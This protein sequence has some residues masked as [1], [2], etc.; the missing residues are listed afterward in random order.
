MKKKIK[1]L[2]IASLIVSLASLLYG[3][4]QTCHGHPNFDNPLKEEQ[5]LPLCLPGVILGSLSIILLASFSKFLS[6]K[7]ID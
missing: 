1:S 2:F 7:F 4:F 3:I 6:R 5:G